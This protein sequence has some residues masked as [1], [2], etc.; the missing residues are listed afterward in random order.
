M[1]KP[2]NFISGLA[3]KLMVAILPIGF[4]YLFLKKN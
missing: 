3:G 4:N 2:H 1:V